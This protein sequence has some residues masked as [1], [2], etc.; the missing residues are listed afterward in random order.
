MFG[1][2]KKKKKK[3]QP[4]EVKKEEKSVVVEE[5]E[6]VKQEEVA[7]TETTEVE[8]D[9]VEE[10][11]KKKRKAINH[12]TKHKDGGWQV[13]KEGAQ[14]ALKKFGTQK[15]AIDF[16]KNIEKEKVLISLQFLGSICKILI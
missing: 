12:I 7:V 2:F 4:V 16:A 9:V 1:L 13:K 10:P 14:R 5:Q 8:K 15:E 11:V 3:A 6:E